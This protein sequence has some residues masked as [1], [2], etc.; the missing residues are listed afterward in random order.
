MPLT[1]PNKTDGSHRLRLMVSDKG[2]GL[3]LGPLLVTIGLL[4]WMGLNIFALPCRRIR[5]CDIVTRNGLTFFFL[6]VLP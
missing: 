6:P 2:P 3:V 1:Q 5:A 4:L